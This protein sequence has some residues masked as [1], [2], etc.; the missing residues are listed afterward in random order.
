[1]NMAKNQ[2]DII[3]SIFNSYFQGPDMI[4]G[5]RALNDKQVV[6]QG[7]PVG[8]SSKLIIDGKDKDFFFSQTTYSGTD[9]DTSKNRQFTV[10]D[11]TNTKTIVL[12]WK[13]N[14]IEGLASRIND[15]L[16]AEPSLQAVAEQVDDDTFQIKSTNTGASAIVEIGGANQTEF[17][18]QQI[19]HG[20]DEKQNASREFT[21]SDGTKTATI[22]LNGNYSSIEG[23]VQ[24]VNMQ[25]EAATVRVQ[26]EKVDA[27]RFALRATAT[28]AQLIGGGTDWNELF[29]D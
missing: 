11:G 29:A 20:E 18:N 6:L 7:F 5:A 3:A 15:Y 28:G 4:A 24:A 25:L 10:S 23:L 1:M 21:V 26:A 14:N 19:F 17:F 9:E 22:L 12:N 27:Q 13:Y 8:A 2:A 16:S